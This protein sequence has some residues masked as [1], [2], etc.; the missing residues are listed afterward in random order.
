MGAIV[1]GIG[2]VIGTITGSKAARD[3]AL[4]ASDMTK[5]Q[6]EL[7]RLFQQQQNEKATANANEQAA[8]T[9][10]TWADTGAAATAQAA[11]N[12]R[13]QDDANQRA[14]AAAE[15]ARVEAEKQRQ[16]QQNLTNISDAQS[17]T[18]K[19]VAGGSAEESAIT[20][21]KTRKRKTSLA[22]NLGIKV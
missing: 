20:T 6:S 13:M 3:A 11:E 8:A 22:T 5:Y 14:A 17:N 1:K 2:N 19:V 4:E 16:F 10:Q 18:P 12:T 7:N 9:R 15:A 21:T